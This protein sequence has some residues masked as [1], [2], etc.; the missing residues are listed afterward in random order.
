MYQLHG[1]NSNTWH[2]PSLSP[3]G[4]DE[5]VSTCLSHVFCIVFNASINFCFSSIF[6]TSQQYTFC[7]FR[8]QPLTG[9]TRTFGNF[10]FHAPKFADNKKVVT[11]SKTFP[12]TPVISVFALFTAWVIRKIRAR[13]LWFFFLFRFFTLRRIQSTCGI[14]SHNAV[15][16]QIREKTSQHASFTMYHII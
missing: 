11:R 8:I 2:D 16:I 14:C 7:L 13:R 5:H 1:D 10:I 3:S 4:H 9:K 12:C 6:Y 15:F